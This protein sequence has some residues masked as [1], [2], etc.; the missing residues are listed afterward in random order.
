ML[1]DAYMIMLSRALIQLPFTEES[2]RKL[3]NIRPQFL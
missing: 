3:A 1:I 2:V